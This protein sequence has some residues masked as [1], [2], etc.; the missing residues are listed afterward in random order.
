MVSAGE[1]VDYAMIVEA[2]IA[3]TWVGCV[4]YR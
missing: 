1:I 4:A 3:E 2:I